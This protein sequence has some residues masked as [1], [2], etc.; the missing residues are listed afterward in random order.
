M[1]FP[2]P[3]TH[4]M[5]MPPSMATGPVAPM[6]MSPFARMGPAMGQTFSALPTV[7]QQ[8]EYALAFLNHQK[9]QI[10]KMREYFHECIKSL[11]ASQEV[12]EQEV[13][14]IDAARSERKRSKASAASETRPKR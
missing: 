13:S 14:K 7:E 1:D 11:D 4:A 5:F 2:F 8:E 10:A 6:P 3:F 12:I 9:Q